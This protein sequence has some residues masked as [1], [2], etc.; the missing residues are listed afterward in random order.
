M[1]EPTPVNGQIT[2]A[3][4]QGDLTALGNAPAMAMGTLYQH[5]AHATGILFQNAV[6]AQQQAAITAQAATVQGVATLY[7]I[8]TAATGVATQK[9]FGSPAAKES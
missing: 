4:T 3:I 5:M 8:D 9:I 7:S 1:A 6:A 2:D